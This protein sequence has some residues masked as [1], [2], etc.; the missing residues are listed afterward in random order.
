MPRDA[1]KVEANAAREDVADAP[2]ID[3]V[4]VQN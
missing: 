4:E 2:D 3:V 1:A